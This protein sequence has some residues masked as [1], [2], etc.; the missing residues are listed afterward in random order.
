MVGCS[1]SNSKESSKT[2]PYLIGLVMASNNGA[3]SSTDNS[4]PTANPT[5]EPAPT[6][7]QPTMLAFPSSVQLERFISVEKSVI[8]GANGTG[9]N[10]SLIIFSGHQ[11]ELNIDLVRPEPL[12]V[13]VLEDHRAKFKRILFVSYSPGMSVTNRFNKIYPLIKNYI[14]G[15]VTLIGTS[16]GTLYLELTKNRLKEEGV[17]VSLTI[18]NV[19]IRKG[20]IA[21]GGYQYLT[22]DLSPVGGLVEQIEPEI[23]DYFPDSPFI[24][25]LQPVIQRNISNSDYCI[26]MDYFNSGSDLVT[27]VDSACVGILTGNRLRL[28][29]DHDINKNLT[30]LESVA[31]GIKYIL[32]NHTV[33]VAPYPYNLLLPLSW[34]GNQF[35]PA[36]IP[37][38]ANTTIAVTFERNVPGFTVSTINGNWDV[39]LVATMTVINLEKNLIA[40]KG[41]AYAKDTTT[42]S[43][44]FNQDL[45][46]EVVYNK[47]SGGSPRAL[48]FAD[49]PYYLTSQARLNLQAPISSI[50]IMSVSAPIHFYGAYIGIQDHK[51]FRIRADI[52][53]HWEKHESFFFFNVDRT[54]DVRTNNL[55]IVY[56][57]GNPTITGSLRLDGWGLG[58]DNID[59]DC[60]FVE[61]SRTA[62]YITFTSPQTIRADL[63]GIT[64][65]ETSCA[66][67]IG[68][69]ITL[70][71]IK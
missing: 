70:Q 9:Q 30:S 16:A 8:Y 35:V 44:F 28:A 22:R 58:V 3:S 60:T 45:Q 29:G 4:T 54:I 68:G 1:K 69:E 32:E 41:D 61:K 57:N 26:A 43:Y 19:G 13:R 31:R 64:V 34:D 6:T 15:N 42:G 67:L 25:N 52:A 14:E 27:K 55:N 33:P 59:T 40:L 62:D 38:L 37:A 56:T 7:T 39:R 63:I 20:I 5:T 21:D 11:H 49:Y 66:S 50:N 46:G 24:N 17:S 23:L 2:L 47:E 53:G 65:G 10:N 51:N 36:M 48:G 12:A 71:I 18:S